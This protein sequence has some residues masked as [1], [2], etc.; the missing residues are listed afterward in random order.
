M[1]VNCTCIFSMREV[2]FI[3]VAVQQGLDDIKNALRSRGYQVVDLETYRYPI[4]AIIYT[5]RSFQLSH[6]TSNN[7]QQVSTGIRDNYGILMINAK[8][9]SIDDIERIL[10]SRSYSPLF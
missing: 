9:K 8:E 2:F 1:N 7:F 6:I 3:I 4:D 5:G 10:I